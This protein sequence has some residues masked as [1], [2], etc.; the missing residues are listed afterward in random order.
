LNKNDV[1]S[2]MYQG[3]TD[4]LKWRDGFLAGYAKLAAQQQAQLA[5]YQMDP[6][7]MMY[8]LLT[9]PDGMEQLVRLAKGV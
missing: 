5:L 2:P 4:F 8:L 7:M 9:N 6:K 3:L 1:V